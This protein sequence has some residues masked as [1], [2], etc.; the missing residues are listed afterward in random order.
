MSSP[1]SVGDSVEWD[2]GSGTAVG[3]VVERF[4]TRVER[5]LQGAD[6][7]RNASDSEPAFLIEQDDGAE[8]LKS[9]TEVRR[10]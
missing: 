2:W 10:T 5:T 1:I 6:V 8:V 4:T 3:T 7:T 9:V